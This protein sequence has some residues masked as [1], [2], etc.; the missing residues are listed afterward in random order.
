MLSFSIRTFS[1][2]KRRREDH[3]S[4]QFIFRIGVIEGFQ[5]EHND[6]VWICQTVSVLCSRK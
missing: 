3:I 6:V 4:A 2:E 1:D 5:S